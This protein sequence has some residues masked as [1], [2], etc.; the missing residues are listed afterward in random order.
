MAPVDAVVQSHNTNGLVLIARQTFA[1]HGT[2]QCTGQC[3]NFG[4]R[5]AFAVIKDRAAQGKL[6]FVQLVTKMVRT[7]ALAFLIAS[8]ARATCQMPEQNI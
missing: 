1:A 2:A 5:I 7:W 6:A 4:G 8:L 3:A